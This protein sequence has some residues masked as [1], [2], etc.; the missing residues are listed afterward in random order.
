M[1]EASLPTVPSLPVLQVQQPADMPERGLKL[2]ADVVVIG[3][4]ASG[5]VAAYELSK[6]GAKVVVL[7]AGPYVKSEQF[8]ER[9]IKSFQDLYA[10]GGNQTNKSGDLVVLQGACIGGSTVVN[11]AVCFRTPDAVLRAWGENY[12]L[13]N[14]SPETMAPYFDKVEKNLHI[15]P[16]GP[17]EINLNGRLIWDGAKKVGIPGGPASRNIEQCA[18]TGH[19]I[20]GCKT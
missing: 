13:D 20:A 7:E 9:L 1:T 6:A 17:H 15:H 11:A 3:S 19:C 12:G 5:A 14:L 2:E 18:L 10:E 16:N 4:G 8:T